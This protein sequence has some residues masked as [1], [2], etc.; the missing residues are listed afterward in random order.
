MTDLPHKLLVPGVPLRSNT[1]PNGPDRRRFARPHRLRR[2]GLGPRPTAAQRRPQQTLREG[3]E[4]AHGA[5]VG[6]QNPRGRVS[7]G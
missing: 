3:E 2:V 5:E 1:P 4:W 7:I 6:G